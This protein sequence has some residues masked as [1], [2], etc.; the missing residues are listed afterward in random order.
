M[1]EQTIDSLCQDWKA[2]LMPFLDAG[3]AFA[4]AVFHKEGRLLYANH[5]MRILL[6]TEQGEHQP[7][8]YLI[9]PNFAD[10]INRSPLES[11]VFEGFLTLGNGLD[12]SRTIFGKAYRRGDALLIIGEY[13]VL[14]LDYMNRQMAQLNQEISNLQRKLIKEKHSLEK[15]L[16]ELKQTQA[17]LIQSEKMNAL[18]QLVAGVAHEINNPLAYVFSNIHSLKES[19]ADICQA[20][21][22]LEKLI[23]QSTEEK[24]IADCH[25]IREQYD[26]SFL[27]EDFEDLQRASLQGLD[28]VKRI[29]EDLRNFSRLDESEIKPIDLLENLKSTVSLAQ[30]EL[31]KRQ[32][33]LKLEVEPE[34]NLE[35]YPALFNQVLLNLIVNAAQS[36]DGGG[37][38][39]LSARAENDTIRIDV[40]DTG[41]GISA[42]QLNQIFNPFFTTKPV[43][44]GT[45]LGLSIA[46]QIIHEKHG[47]TIEVASVPDQGTTFTITVPREIKTNG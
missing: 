11:P 13:D 6:E 17:M 45:G 10:L 24:T 25:R 27:F 31:R 5:G 38:L 32:V 15:A 43:G 7:A 4:I 9:N 36:M 44:Q 28:R 12:L 18:G 30:P 19:F 39:T 22:A 2:E 29:V 26:I 3:K 42:E 14:E 46:Y 33:E 41:C 35:C 47:G 40:S 23:E 20:Y 16:E 34:L 37:E 8:D 1:T 21:E